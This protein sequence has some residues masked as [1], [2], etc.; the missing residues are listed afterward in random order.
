MDRARRCRR[1][2]KQRAR[3]VERA[4]GGAW[5]GA[6]PSAGI[7]AVGA[8][9]DAAKASSAA[10]VASVVPQPCPSASPSRAVRTS[11]SRLSPGEADAAARVTSARLRASDGR[12]ADVAGWSTRPA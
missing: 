7:A 2:L 8:C 11:G 6:L 1:C 12:I 10:A 4:G 5:T 9:Q 3:G